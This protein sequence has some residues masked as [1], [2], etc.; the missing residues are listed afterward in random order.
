MGHNHALNNQKALHDI[1]EK[2]DE[3]GELRFRRCRLDD[4]IPER[5]YDVRFEL[6]QASCE[7][8]DG[9]NQRNAL[10]QSQLCVRAKNTVT[11]EALIFSAK[12][13]TLEHQGEETA[14]SAAVLI[15]IP[16]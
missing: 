5:A 3:K 13:I 4:N 8:S 7:P 16:R 9:V 14:V 15:V 11:S 2:H 10:D 1:H 12:G 6:Q